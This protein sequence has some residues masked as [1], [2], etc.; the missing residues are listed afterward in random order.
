[1]PAKAIHI[2]NINRQIVSRLPLNIER[3]I[4]RIGE[5]VAPR[6]NAQVK[7]YSAA[8]DQRRVGQDYTRWIS[9]GLR[10]ECRAPGIR[11]RGCAR[12][13][14]SG[15]RRGTKL[16]IH[17]RLLL[18]DAEWAARRDGLRHARGQI[19]IQLAAVVVHPPPC[20][21]YDFA[22]K[23]LRA[24]GNSKPRCQSPLAPS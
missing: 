3:A 9:R 21:D 11:E 10:T 1:M 13:E 8:F 4:H 23:H 17:E 12:L 22:V 18:V 19:G 2:S 24:P 6:V 20:A 16:R 15:E 7:G 5:L 14:S